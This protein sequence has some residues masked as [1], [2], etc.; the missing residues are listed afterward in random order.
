MN[1]KFSL[2]ALIGILYFS[3]MPMNKQQV[4]WHTKAVGYSI[5]MAAS[6]ALIVYSLIEIPNRSPLDSFTSIVTGVGFTDYFGKLA[7]RNTM[8]AWKGKN[9]KMTFN[10]INAYIV[11]LSKEATQE[12]TTLIQ[13]LAES[14]YFDMSVDLTPQDGSQTIP[15]TLRIKTIATQ[16]EPTV[17]MLAEYLK[18]PITEK[19]SEVEI[20]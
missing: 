2:F 3:L 5:A 12:I 17:Q 7:Y 20:K 18:Q 16:Q 6:G 8:Q 1:T 10:D 14:S 11:G 15:A 19:Q 9:L 4:A 13:K